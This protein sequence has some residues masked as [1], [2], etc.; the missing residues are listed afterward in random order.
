MTAREFYSL[1]SNGDMGLGQMVAPMSQELLFSQCV[2]LQGHTVY[3]VM[4]RATA[5]AASAEVSRIGVLSNE[6]VDG[7]WKI[8][9]PVSMNALA[10]HLSCE[11]M[12]ATVVEELPLQDVQ[13]VTILSA[14]LLLAA[15]DAYNIKELNKERAI[16]AEQRATIAA[17]EA[18]L[19]ALQPQAPPQQYMPQAIQQQPPAAVAPP[20]DATGVLT[21]LGNLLGQREKKQVGLRAI[22]TN[23]DVTS[24]EN[25]HEYLGNENDIMVVLMQV[26]R[27]YGFPRPCDKE[28]TDNLRAAMF[29]ALRYGFDEHNKNVLHN[30]FVRFRAVRQLGVANAQAAIAKLDQPFV[31]DIGKAIAAAAKAAPATTTKAKA[32]SAQGGSKA[33]FN[34]GAYGHK[35]AACPKN[36][37]GGH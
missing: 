3:V 31:D 8:E 2:A 6:S 5:S 30:A 11:I 18:R 20:M 23:M 37:K 9:F 15:K 17:L 10:K 7:K 25:W 22:G 21:L 19:A 13:Y 35:A 32:P 29:N 34:C 24:T 36:A 33:C 26:Y 4:K 14:P 16:V 1:G 12:A 28:V 27:V